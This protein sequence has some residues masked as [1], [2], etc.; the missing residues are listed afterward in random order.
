[1]RA[2]VDIGTHTLRPAQ[3]EHRVFTNPLRVESARRADHQFLEPAQAQRIARM[4]NRLTGHRLR[5]SD[6]WVA[7]R[8]E[9][10]FPDA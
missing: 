4:R 5:L 10:T 9:T 2:I 1:M 3:H 8:R 6:L 7:H